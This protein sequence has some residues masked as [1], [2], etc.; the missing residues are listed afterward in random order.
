MFSYDYARRDGIL[1]ITWDEFGKMTAQLAEKLASFQLEAIVGLARGG[2]FPATAAACM[3]RVEFYPARLTRRMND[4]V[5]YTHP[6]WKT[7]VSAE[8]AGKT[9]AVVD[10]IADSG[11]TLTLAAGQARALGARKVITACL[12][13]H[14]W[15]SPAPDV[16]V[17]VTDALVLFPWDRRVLIDGNWQCHPELSAALKAQELDD[18]S[19]W[20]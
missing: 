9:I 8:V 3:L 10:E 6:A 2:L 13:S 4:Q 16:T 18:E 1:P 20:D 17:L 5:V 7:T 15:A 14:T 12:V 19:L 11:E